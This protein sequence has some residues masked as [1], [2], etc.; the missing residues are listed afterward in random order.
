[1]P[2]NTLSAQPDLWRIERRLIAL[3][4]ELR[5]TEHRLRTHLLERD[6]VWGEH[7]TSGMS[8]ICRVLAEAMPPLRQRHDRDVSSG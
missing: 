6:R 3:E 2:D 1:M 8:L 5:L 7:L 4:Y